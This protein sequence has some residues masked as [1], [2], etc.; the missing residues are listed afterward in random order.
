MLSRVSV[1]DDDIDD[2]QVVQGECQF[3]ETHLGCERNPM[4]LSDRDV[5][6]GRR[7]DVLGGILNLGEY[8]RDLWEVVGYRVEHGMVGAV[9][10]GV[11]CNLKFYDLVWGRQLGLDD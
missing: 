1:F 5:L 6:E 7:T 8:R 10:H 4:S 9:V 3:T 11:E 2:R